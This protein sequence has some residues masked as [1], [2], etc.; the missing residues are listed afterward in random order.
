M[1]IKCRFLSLVL[2]GLLLSIG[3]GTA[4]AAGH[5]RLTWYGQSAFKIVTPEGHVLLLDPWI[6]NP[7]N[8]DGKQDLAALDKVDFILITHG[9]SDH[10][11]NA[12]AIAK[13]T[14]AKL[15][16]NSDLGNALVAEA[17]YPADQA[18]MA[19]LGNAGGTITILNGEVS[20][21]IVPAVHG[22][23]FAAGD[24]QRAGG[25]PDGFVIR[26]KNGP[27]IY[28]TGDTD[29]FS[30]M[31]LI[32]EFNHIDVMLACIGGHF[33]MDPKRAALAVKFVHPDVVIPMHYG[34][35]PLLAGTPA[36]FS[37]ALKARHVDTRL[38][39]MKI[40]QTLSF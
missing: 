10:V 4:L 20:V 3:A 16:T 8:P 30:D 28:D 40:G 15:L 29:V 26:I 31:K 6:T 23:T 25:N 19:T 21:T 37:K 34:T 18:T 27:T 33:T 22:S 7:V 11:G 2:S 35:F 17:G 5:T 12:V 14:G 13:R 9:H 36:E 1:N 39:V 38:D 24:A 32:P